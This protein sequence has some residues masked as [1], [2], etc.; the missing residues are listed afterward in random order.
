MFPFGK[1]W[2][3]AHVYIGLFS[4]L[5]N[6]KRFQGLQIKLCKT[7]SQHY[8]HY[9]III[10]VFQAGDFQSGTWVV[11]PQVWFC[12]PALAVLLWGLISFWQ[13][14]HSRQGFHHSDSWPEY[15]R[16][17][18]LFD[19]GF[20]SAPLHL[21]VVVWVIFVFLLE[22]AKGTEQENCSD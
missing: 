13:S 5:K 4:V 17:C 10:W 3:S 1:S 18:V 14:A 21:H 22:S 20:L 19:L 16:Q 8:C 12:P 2:N 9:W 15:Q 7:K 6:C 11:L